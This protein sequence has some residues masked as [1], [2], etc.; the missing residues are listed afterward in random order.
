MSEPPPGP[1]V[2]VATE[3]TVRALA[4]IPLV[5]PGD[6]LGMLLAEAIG[7][8]PR[9]ADLDVVVIASKLLSRAEGAFVDLER[10]EPTPQASLLAGEVDKDPRLVQ[11]ILD[12]CLHISRKAPGVL[13]TRHRLGH[14]SANSG[15]DA[16]N[17]QPEGFGDDGRWVLRLPSAPDE[18]ARQI[19]ATLEAQLGVTLGV[20]VTDSLGRPF[21]RGSVGHVVGIAGLP[22]VS[23][24]R[25]AVDVCGLEL[26]H[27]FIAVGDMVAAAADLV[28]GQAGA[29][30]G[31]AIVR[32][33]SFEPTALDSSELR[34]HPDRDLYA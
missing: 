1:R 23:D 6:D 5:C 18:A 33:L 28:M 3:L 24:E 12:D 34:R 2:H 25:G 4:G 14:V 27:T 20:V 30:R 9:L 16:S 32:G 15:I 31:A 11:V 19:R 10:I 22:P 7:R 13:I 21:R 29:G 26:Q 8:G 17:A